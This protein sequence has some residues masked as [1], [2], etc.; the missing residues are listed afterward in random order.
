MELEYISEKQNEIL[1]V[2]A[3]SNKGCTYR[4]DHRG[5]GV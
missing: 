5:D 2:L 3:E 4:R 1:A